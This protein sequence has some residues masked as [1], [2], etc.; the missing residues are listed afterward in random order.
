MPEP[1]VESPEA[2]K[3]VTVKVNEK[4]VQLPKRRVTGLEIKRAAID[5]GVEIKIDFEL[6]EEAHGKKLARN[7]ADDEHIT[8]SEH[9]EFLAVDPEEDS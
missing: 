8:V 2:R 9:S 7:I 6:T 4:A 5:A 1:E 3:S